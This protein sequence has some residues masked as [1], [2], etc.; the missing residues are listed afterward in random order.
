[1]TNEERNVMIMAL[2]SLEYHS[3]GDETTEQI[4]DDLRQCIEQAERQQAI[5]KMA[6]NERQLGIQ[7]QPK[8][9]AYAVKTVGGRKWHSIH[10]SKGASD[11]WLEYRVKEQAQGEQYEQHAL[12]T[13]PPAAQEPDYKA[14][15]QQMCERCDELDKELAAQP[16]PVQEP[17]VWL[18]DDK[19]NKY[20][21]PEANKGPLLKRAEEAYEAAK[22]REW[23]GLSEQERND[24]EDDC[25]MIVGKPAFDA[26]EAKLCEK[27]K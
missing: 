1:M 21:M 19:G 22:Q 15:W 11:K 5:D 14:L 10:A 9:E 4:I 7:M 18:E 27:N 6:E 12:Y 17:F 13:T 16:A 2:L 20:P 3:P 26:I 23:V 24:I 25:E 8:P